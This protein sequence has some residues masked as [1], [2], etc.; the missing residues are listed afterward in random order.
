MLVIKMNRKG[1]QKELKE[2]IKELDLML[3]SELCFKQGTIGQIFVRE[4]PKLA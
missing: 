1:N 4:R 2:F 3:G